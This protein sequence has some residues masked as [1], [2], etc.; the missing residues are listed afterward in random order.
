MVNVLSIPVCIGSNTAPSR[1]LI[2]LG[3][4]L[5]TS[6]EVA[7]KLGYGDPGWEDVKEERFVYQELAGGIGIPQLLFAGWQCEYHILVLELLGPSLGDLH[8][9]CDWHFSLKTILLIADQAI[10][11]IEYIHSKGYIHRDM[12]PENFVMG[13]GKNGNTLYLIDFGAAWPFSDR[14]PQGIWRT[15]RL[16]GTVPF[17]SLNNHRGLRK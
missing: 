9:Y 11:R 14:L 17:A 6:Q 8:S 5:Y 2:L 15:G 12:K 7:I 4:D 13:S 1:R 10:S 16:V 3:T